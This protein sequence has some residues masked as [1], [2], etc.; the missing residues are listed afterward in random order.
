MRSITA[1]RCIT[2]PTAVH[3]AYLSPPPPLAHG[4]CH[5]FPPHLWNWQFMVV[6]EYFLE[7]HLGEENAYQDI[8]LFQEQ[9]IESYVA[10]LFVL[11]TTVLNTTLIP[12]LESPYTA[13]PESSY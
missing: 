10:Y 12:P 13:K 6:L 1:M 8:S 11:F 7:A 4:T 2:L 3:A 5:S 9:T